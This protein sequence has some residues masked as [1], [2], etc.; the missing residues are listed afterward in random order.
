VINHMTGGIVG[1]KGSNGTVF[2]KYDYPGVYGSADFH[3]PRAP[4]WLG[5]AARARSRAHL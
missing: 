3:Q 4:S 5:L 2:S 1:S